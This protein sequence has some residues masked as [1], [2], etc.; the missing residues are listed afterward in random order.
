M[1]NALA[2]GVLDDTLGAPFADVV[3]N[4][5]GAFS[6]NARVYC[7]EDGIDAEEC[8][9][10]AAGGLAKHLVV[11]QCPHPCNPYRGLTYDCSRSAL[12][13]WYRKAIDKELARLEKEKH[14]LNQRIA[15][16]QSAWRIDFGWIRRTPC[17]NP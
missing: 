17:L 15:P 1:K 16:D 7:T 2:Y 13:K 11:L 5:Q 4:A 6:A 14:S 3:I 10:S 9:D 8:V 12:K